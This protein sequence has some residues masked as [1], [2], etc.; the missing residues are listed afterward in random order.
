MKTSFQMMQIYP[1]FPL[2]LR[3]LRNYEKRREMRCNGWIRK[4]T[5]ASIGLWSLIAMH[6][7]RFKLKFNASTREWD[8]HFLICKDLTNT[9]LPRNPHGINIWIQTPKPHNILSMQVDL[10]FTKVKTHECQAHN[11]C[12]QVDLTIHEVNHE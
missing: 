7:S 9:N 4:W 12:K 2:L 3:V 6:A 5:S 1:K 8:M 10:H 11:M